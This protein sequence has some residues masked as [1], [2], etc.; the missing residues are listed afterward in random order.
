MPDHHLPTHAKS[1]TYNKKMYD[2]GLH[3]VFIRFTTNHMK[4]L[5]TYNYIFV[6]SIAV[7]KSYSKQNVME[8]SITSER[9]SF[10][11]TPTVAPG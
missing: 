9:Y 8:D 3:Q 11:T 1:N 2:G 4:T 10:S 7:Q 6:F 5:E